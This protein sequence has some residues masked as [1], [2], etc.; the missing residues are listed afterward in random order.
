MTVENSLRRLTA[1]NHLSP[2]QLERLA[3]ASRNVAVAAGH[4]VVRRGDQSHR[5]CGLIG[6]ALDVQ[7]ET[8]QGDFVLARLRPGDLL[9][10]AAF[11]DRL[12]RD[13]DV[14]AASDSELIALESEKIEQLCADD[15]RFQQALYW[16]MWKGMSAKLR[17]T[18]RMIGH[19]FAGQQEDS[20]PT[21]VGAPRP[22][23]PLEIGARA[24]R[25]LL[26]RQDLTH[27]EANFL[28]SLSTAR[29]FAGGETIFRESERGTTLYFVVDG[30]VRI[31][32]NIPG[33]GEEA[34]A[35]LH[36]GEV[37]G[38]MALVDGRPRSADAVAHENDVELL[39]VPAAV[40][41]RLLDIDGLSS[42][43]LL[44]KLCRTL[45]RRLRSL[46]AKIVGWYL[47]SGGASTVIAGRDRDI[48]S[49]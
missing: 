3:E 5:L 19:H 28:A 34:L 17:I 12:P 14:V 21:T 13:T 29:R 46:N 49:A 11:V 48:A 16:A 1:L 7:R 6:G 39:E 43:V 2:G 40:V 32:K 10:E 37:F 45:A 8:P 30:E 18:T 24:K 27:L 25:D 38:E 44:E 26:L 15:R 47:I 35:I 33:S 20:S 23:I 9:G 41:S 22:G 31:S 4:A 36:P 42:S